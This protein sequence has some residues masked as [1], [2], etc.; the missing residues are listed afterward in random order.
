VKGGQLFF[1]ALGSY[2]IGFQR[3]ITDEVTWRSGND[4]IGT[5][6]TPGV[7]TGRAAGTVQVWA[8]SGSQRSEMIG[9]EV[10]ETSEVTYCDAANVNRGVWSDDFNR[11]TL[12]SD[13]DQYTRPG[14]V[15]LRYT[16]TETQPHGGIFDPCLDLYIYR[17]DQKIRT[18]REEGCGEP[19][20][21]RGAPDFADAVLKYQLR[22]FWDLKDE[23]GQVVAPATYTVF[24]RFYLYYDPVVSIDISVQ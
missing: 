17:G 14:V 19:F 7:F 3:D 23:T 1:H 10:Y 4:A 11:V 20:L 12:E 2:D 21:A 5:F 13:C 22:A 6:T 18:L 15:T 8:E 24:G 9:L 16:V